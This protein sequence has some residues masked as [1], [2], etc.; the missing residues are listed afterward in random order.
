MTSRR[1]RARGLLADLG[2]FRRRLIRVLVVLVAGAVFGFLYSPRLI[3]LMLQ[4]VGELIYLAP[5]EAFMVHVRV[6]LAT[7]FVIALPYALTSLAAFAGRRIPKTARRQLYLVLALGL[8]LFVAG[9][10]FAATVVVPGVLA[11]FMSFA[12]DKVKPLLDL[13]NYVGFVFG[14][15]IPFGLVFQLPLTIAALAR[16]GVLS[17]DTLVRNRRIVILIIFIVAAILTPPDAVSQLLMAGP[18]FV[19]FELGIVLARLAWRRRAPSAID[20]SVG[21]N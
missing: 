11:F 9:T 18:L 5:S 19:L 2:D 12:S 8:V 15:V 7:G 14:T 17:P 1:D 13:S 4:P 16:V 21:E 6:A 10:A 3:E 20:D